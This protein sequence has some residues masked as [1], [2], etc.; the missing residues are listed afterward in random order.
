MRY[1]DRLETC[2]L[3]VLFSDGLLTLHTDKAPLVQGRVE[4]GLVRKHGVGGRARGCKGA[5]WV[6]RGL[7]FTES[8]LSAY[9]LRTPGYL[10]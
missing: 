7:R 6:R 8:A 10:F 9:M 4:G 2:H 5:V 1:L 3:H